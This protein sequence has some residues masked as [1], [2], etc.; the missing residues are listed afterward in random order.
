MSAAASLEGAFDGSIPGTAQVQHS[1]SE[2][3][4][5]ALRGVPCTV[6]GIHPDAHVVPV[7]D[8]LRPASRS[9]RQLLDHCRGATLDVGCG[10]GRM[11]AH[12]ALHGHPVLGV[13][14]VREAV[15]EARRR[16]VPVLRRNVFAPMPG[17]GSWDTVLLA[18]GNIGIGGDPLALLRRAAELL[19]HGGRVVCDLAG[20]GT[21][22]RFHVARLVTRRRTTATFPWAQVGPDAIEQ[23]GT[24]AGLT[25]VHVGQRHGTWFA[26]LV[27]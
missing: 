25:L 20:P 10:P 23:L 21:G 14:I 4:G 7:H 1:F 12:L 24:D 17:E 18:D 26:V 19:T 16:G 22:L 6:H 13:D 3:F 27:R 8:W 2:V 15:E 9:D 5:D 11:S